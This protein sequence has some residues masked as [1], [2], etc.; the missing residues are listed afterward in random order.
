MKPHVNHEP[1][2]T[3]ASNG[4]EFSIKATSEAFK[5]LSSGLYTYKPLAVVRELSC[6]AYDA[7]VAAGKKDVPFY[8]HLPTPLEPWLVI[9]DDGVGL[10]EQQVYDLYGTYFSST[11]QDSNDFIGAKG[12]GSKSPFS[13]TDQFTITSRYN[14]VKASYLAYIGDNGNPTISLVDTVSTDEENGVEVYVD[15][16]ESDRH[17]FISAAHKVFDFF[18]IKPI[19]NV[20]EFSP[21][22]F[23][24]ENDLYYI[25]AQKNIQAPTDNTVHAVMG[26]VAYPI[27]R[28]YVNELFDVV[29]SNTN[30][31]I[32][33]PLGELD[34]N[35]GRED[36]SLDDETIENL[37]TRIELV[38]NTIIKDMQTNFD[39]LVSPKEVN[40]ETTKK[41]DSFY[42]A[43]DTF[44]LN[45]RQLR[46]YFVSVQ[47]LLKPEKKDLDNGITTTVY[48]NKD[49]GIAK[50]N[51]YTYG[52]K[53]KNFLG[54][55]GF[56]NNHGLTFN[57][58]FNPFLHSVTVLF[59]DKKKY[60]NHNL[61][62]LYYS[63]SHDR[64]VLLV[65]ERQE[66]LDHIKKKLEHFN[67]SIEVLSERI[68][69]GCKPEKKQTSTYSRAEFG[70]QAY[71][72]GKI[73]NN[74]NKKMTKDELEEELEQWEKDGFKI[75]VCETNFRSN[76]YEHIDIQKKHFK[77]GK[78]DNVV[79]VNLP[80]KKAQN[81]VK[82]GYASIR[83]F[84][85]N[86]ELVKMYTDYTNES[87]E[88]QYIVENKNDSSF[89][90]SGHP[91]EDFVVDH[92]ILTNASDYVKQYIANVKK[93]KKYK[94]Y[95]LEYYQ[96]FKGIKP[97][98]FTF[99]DMQ[100]Y[101]DQRDKFDDA[102]AREYP[103]IEH[104][105]QSSVFNSD[106][107]RELINYIEMVNQKRGL[108]REQRV[109]KVA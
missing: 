86:D 87:R 39:G 67:V 108:T 52:V 61:E 63:K 7:H 22:E 5:I 33:F 48:V 83:D 18:E 109:S 78:H 80:I 53:R 21:F 50:K 8:V 45:G 60:I 46:D 24:F 12:L 15:V 34:T 104:I 56:L 107:Q 23:D 54:E 102:I 42:N 16:R 19:F 41:L 94:D 103:L 65:C 99:D 96:V 76:H 101:D 85:F 44:S 2:L 92:L 26:N 62:E 79:F 3:N 36:L 37:K 17:E 72:N 95:N 1:V 100:K 64:D 57:L 35:A 84:E 75:Y 6:N 47:D 58:T 9:K 74:I 51:T 13:Y 4:N 93:A 73:Y 98:Y 28:K 25:D 97:N 55:D 68:D 20:K 14:G 59:V 90:M 71:K 11:K 31:Y 43:Y 106:A 81:Y 66:T 40:A 30:I 32:K 88:V 77:H 70:V 89:S 10:S 38:K 27:N 105:K 91:I 69:A 29:R 49:L 82:K